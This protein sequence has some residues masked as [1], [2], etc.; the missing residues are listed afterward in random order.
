MR[1]WSSRGTEEAGG[2]DRAS[3]AF[4]INL[5][6]NL[7]AILLLVQSKNGEKSRLNQASRLLPST[8]KVLLKQ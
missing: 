6:L 2:K 1:R 5:F 8:Y 4:A 3:S 7:L